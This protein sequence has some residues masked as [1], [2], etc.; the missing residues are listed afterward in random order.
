MRGG[1]NFSKRFY[2]T[3]A[4]GRIP[5]LVDT[6]CLLPFES[7]MTWKDHIVSAGQNELGKL[8]LAIVD[9]FTRHEAMGLERL[10]RGCRGLWEESLSF[11]GFHRRLV[12]QILSSDE[13]GDPCRINKDNSTIRPGK[14]AMESNRV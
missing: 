2:E 5:A 8:P 1:G 10:K 9:H 12:R 4:M 3:L 7:T 13:A 11:G 14:P 6:D